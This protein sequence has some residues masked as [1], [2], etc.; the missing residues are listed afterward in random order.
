[1]SAN[2]VRVFIRR[3]KAELKRHAI[4]ETVGKCIDV[5]VLPYN[6]RSASWEATLDRDMIAT[7]TVDLSNTMR[8]S[9]CSSATATSFDAG[10]LFLGLRAALPSGIGMLC[11]RWR[12][13]GRSVGIRNQTLVTEVTMD[14]D[15]AIRSTDTDA[16]QAR[17]SAVSKGY[18]PDD[19]FV[20]LFVQRAR[21]LPPRPPLINVGTYV[22]ATAIDTLV[23]QWMR[24]SPYIQIVNLG[25]GSDTRYFRL[26]VMTDFGNPG[27][28]IH[29]LRTDPPE[30][31]KARAAFT[32]C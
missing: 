16:A 14:Q 9:A 7:R 18:I 28:V 11:W 32:V 15:A 10:A 20:H 6:G 23:E 2:D 29:S 26:A 3:G 8:T 22:R 13:R 31:R 17:L 12:T 4:R 24:F 1:M 19:P 27:D 21:F 5:V 30:R 25:A